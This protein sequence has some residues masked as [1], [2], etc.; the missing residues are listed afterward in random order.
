MIYQVSSTTRYRFRDGLEP[1]ITEISHAM[2]DGFNRRPG[3]Q[4][5]RSLHRS[6]SVKTAATRGTVS[7]WLVVTALVVFPARIVLWLLM[8]TLLVCTALGTWPAPDPVGRRA[9]SF[10]ESCRY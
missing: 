2:L 7:P 5:R 4:E 10:E 3:R 6:R 9:A 1:A 8:L